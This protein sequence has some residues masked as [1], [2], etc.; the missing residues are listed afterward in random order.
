V[1]NVFP[2]DLSMLAITLTAP[3]HC[4]HVSISIPKTRLSLCSYTPCSVP[5]YRYFQIDLTK[6]D[7]TFTI[8]KADEESG[9]NGTNF[10]VSWGIGF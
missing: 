4:S 7:F 8:S 3:P 2:A 6:G 9:S 10:A 5:Y 1:Q